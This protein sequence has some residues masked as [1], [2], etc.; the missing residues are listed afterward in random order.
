MT[1]IAVRVEGLGKQYFIGGQQARYET[2]RD[3]L[4]NALTGPIRRARKLLRGQA[5][6]AAELDETIWALR[7][8]SFE[9]KQG[10][11]VGIIG[12]NGAGKSTL[13]KV[14]SRITEPTEGYVELYGRVGSLLEVGTGFHNELTGRE[15]VYLNGSILGMSRSEIDRKFDEIVAFSEVETFIDTP[16]KHY[17]S[18]MQVRLAFAVAAHLEPEILV[19]DEVLS[20]GDIAFQR[21]C[22]GKMNDVASEGRTVLF[23][24]HNMATVENLCERGIVL[25]KGQM[26]FSGTQI[27]AIAQYLAAINRRD[28]ALR[29]RTD[30][31]GS[32]EI[33]ITDITFR[34]RSGQALEVVKSGQDV[35]VLFHYEI[36]DP[37]FQ[38]EGVHVSL[39]V[40]NQMDVPVFLQ[41]TRFAGRQLQA[42]PRE[43]TFVC[44]I[45]RLPLPE[46]G[47]RIGYSLRKQKRY[48]DRLPDALD[49]TVVKGDFFG[50]GRVPPATM[51]IAL[52]DAD[53]SV[54]PVRVAQV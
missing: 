32:G 45:D 18:G 14:L 51:G 47:Y 9:V 11:V 33:I 24:S 26:V 29:D 3:T 34:D 50:S 8:I 23:V 15:N 20:V 28:E 54:E 7:D 17:S 37:D 39:E 25:E 41:S 31:V 48:I 22:L 13:L 40:R 16:V 2:L 12:R 4:V 5:T 21:K 43:G 35:D 46:T 49:F 42:I 1:D 30:R 27:Q 36:R 44:H 6:G 52:V 10:E 38:P 53:W 19:I